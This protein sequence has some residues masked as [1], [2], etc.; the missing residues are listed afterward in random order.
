M[1]EMLR[2]DAMHFQFTPLSPYELRLT[3]EQSYC[4]STIILQYHTISTEV[5]IMLGRWHRQATGLTAIYLGTI[6]RFKQICIIQSSGTLLLHNYRNVQ[7][8]NHCSCVVVVSTTAVMRMEP[9]SSL[10]VSSGVQNPSVP[11]TL[12]WQP[13]SLALSR[14]SS[15]SIP[16]SPPTY[17]IPNLVC[18]FRKQPLANTHA[19]NL[20]Q[21]KLRNTKHSKM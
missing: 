13:T 14:L 16:V 12:L 9:A 18:T 19:K 21:H 17:Y 10:S 1:V 6:N 11:F 15:F 20:M 3:K 8:S 7:T 4:H 5:L 2:S